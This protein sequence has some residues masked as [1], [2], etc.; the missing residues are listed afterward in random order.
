MW[1]YRIG[2][3]RIKIIHY[4]FVVLK[5]EVFEKFKMNSYDAKS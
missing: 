3:L 2:G 1:F 5:L 4:I